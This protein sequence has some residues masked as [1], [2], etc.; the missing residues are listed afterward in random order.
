MV[1]SPTA[2]G[3]E[4]LGLY[5]FIDIRAQFDREK[6]KTSYSVSKGGYKKRRGL[7]L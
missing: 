2:L 7:N 4:F 5:K 3:L 6:S 1:C